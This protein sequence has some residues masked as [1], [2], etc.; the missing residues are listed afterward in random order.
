MLLF[1]FSS[2]PAVG[3][4][5]FWR[6]SEVGFSLPSYSDHSLPPSV[7]FLQLSRPEDVTI[8]SQT[9]LLTISL[10]PPP[11]SHFIHPLRHPTSQRCRIEP[12]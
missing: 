5:A 7:P 12:S 8:L 2:F 11:Q 4:R 10:P 9:L 3:I 6:L 1:C